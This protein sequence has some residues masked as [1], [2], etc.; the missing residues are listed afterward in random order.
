M[1]DEIR[2]V[3]PLKQYRFKLAYGPYLKGSVV[4]MTGLWRDVL[5]GKGII[6][7]VREEQPEPAALLTAPPPARQEPVSDA[8]TLAEP[9]PR[10]RRR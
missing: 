4:Q 8:Y 2:R 9:A 10:A 7:E 1:S 3:R 5:L 6:E